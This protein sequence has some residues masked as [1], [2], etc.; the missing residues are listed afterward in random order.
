MT[1]EAAEKS[2]K[3]REARRLLHQLDVRF[4]LS[5]PA[6]LRFTWRG[7]RMRII[8]RQWAF[9]KKEAAEKRNYKLLLELRHRMPAT[10]AGYES[11]L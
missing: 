9:L 3:F 4:T 1:K 5:Y 11:L 8:E 10:A 7:E 2:R 6:E